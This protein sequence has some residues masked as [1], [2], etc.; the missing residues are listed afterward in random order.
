[1]KKKDIQNKIKLYA[2][3]LGF[4]LLSFTDATVKQNN[5]EAFNLWLTKKQHADMQYLEK[6]ELRKNIT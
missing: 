2:I 4:S 1:M 5:T 3:E 6:K